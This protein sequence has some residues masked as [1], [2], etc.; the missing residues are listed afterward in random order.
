MPPQLKE[1]HGHHDQDINH[2][3]EFESVSPTNSTAL[4]HQLKPAATIQYG[5]H[6]TR[7]YKAEMSSP[8]SANSSLVV[9]E[10]KP[11]QQ[12]LI[13]KSLA[14]IVPSL[15][16]LGPFL[17]SLPG[18]F[19]LLGKYKLALQMLL[20][21]IILAYYPVKPWPA[22]R[23]WFQ[24][25][26]N[27]YDLHH[28]LILEDRDE[29]KGVN[30]NDTNTTNKGRTIDED[31]SLLIYATHPHGIIP[32]HGY[33]WCAFCDQHLPKRYG[34]GALT[35]I[36]MRLP[37]LRTVMG[38]LSCAP[39]TKSVLKHKLS[40]EQENL[41]ILPG[42]VAEIFM[43]SPNSDTIKT[44]RRGLMKL[45]L[46]TGAC[47]VPTYVFGA[48]RFFNQ[49]ATYDGKRRRAIAKKQ[50]LNVTN[51]K[52]L[53]GDSSSSSLST[54][55]LSSAPSLTSL[56]SASSSLT[57]SST[58]TSVTASTRSSLSKTQGK[59]GDP[60][61]IVGKLQQRIS[62]IAKGGFTFF[63]GQYGLPLPYDSENNGLRCCMVFGDPILPVA[64][65]KLGNYNTSGNGNKS[66]MRCEPISNPTEEQIDDLHKRYTDSLLR[67]FEQYKIQ[68]GLDFDDQLILQ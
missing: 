43:S 35:S 16:Y 8:S 7:L 24:L 32:I 66:K 19:L 29:D 3:K 2:K 14:L 36:A 63:W 40:I 18:M 53:L 59:D 23:Q 13:G 46:E 57:F 68:A 39:A 21:D 41:Y 38:W 37:L 31:N 30:S 55:S 56:Q 22:F 4:R 5:R 26:Y 28:N 33:M 42:G 34:F 27:L 25:W 49:L 51:T 47:L 60:I 62:R 17:L 50:N 6:P 54:S 11:W 48:N 61:N 10:L 67:L 44:P 1:Y 58:S 15:F 64:G 65:G 20:V 12:N 45:A 9:T 52:K